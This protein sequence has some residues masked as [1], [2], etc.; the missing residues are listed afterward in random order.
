[1]LPATTAF[2]SEVDSIAMRS[3]MTQLE[4]GAA[5]CG[6]ALSECLPGL[7]QCSRQTP[8]ASGLDDSWQ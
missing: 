6:E 7:L 1:M 3:R 4:T 2:R 8:P 5:S